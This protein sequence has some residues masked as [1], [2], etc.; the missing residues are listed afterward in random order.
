VQDRS[1]REPRRARARGGAT[2]AAG[3]R[4]RNGGDDVVHAGAWT[5]LEPLE[6]RVLLSAD[7]WSL[8]GLL[9]GVTTTASSASIGMPARAPRVFGGGGGGGGGAT[10]VTPGQALIRLDQFFADPRFAGLSG[11]GASS[12]II[13]SGINLSH[14]FFGP[15]ANGDGIA[16]RIRYQYDFADNDADAS[17]HDGHGTNVAGIV[18]GSDGVYPGVAPGAGIIA[19]K[20]F[21]DNGAGAF[22][23]VERALQWTIVNAAAYGIVSVNLSLG[24]GGNWASAMSRYGLGDE[25]AALAAINVIVVAA[26]GN[27]YFDAGSVQGI[28]YPASDPS[29]LAVGAVYAG[30]YGPFFYGGGAQADVTGADVIAPFSQRST[31]VSTLFAP[32]APITGPGLGSGLTT[33]H[34]TSQASP[35]V[36][37]AAVLAN[38]VAERYLGRR[39][40]PSEFR[41]LVFSTG[42]LVV[43]GDDE[44]DNAVNTGATFKRIDMLALGG[45]IYDLANPGGGGGGGGGNAAPTLGNIVTLGGGRPNR[46][47]RLTYS[48]LAAA[49]DEADADGTV[50]RFKIVQVT[51]GMV[52]KGGVPVTPGV[53]TLG[54]GEN[55][56]WVPGVGATGVTTA[57][58]VVATDGASDSATPV[59]VKI[60]LASR[61][62]L[63]QASQAGLGLGEVE[64]GMP[65]GRESARSG[66]VGAGFLGA[67]VS[68]RA[69]VDGGSG[70]ESGVGERVPLSS[71]L[72]LA[73]G[74]VGGLLARV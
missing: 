54:P 71:E 59:G 36:A 17:D 65:P 34:G 62:G 35:H 55:L 19:L 24:D 30:T 73:D 8:S 70:P 7:P 33:M 39:L 45:A 43:D 41:S 56:I 66:G 38:Q 6:A 27:G 64:E 37:G 48:V 5:G 3:W 4:T 23:A 18:A 51:S 57:F 44:Q 49:A 26:A 14:P 46:P 16:D 25:L 53:T 13:D 22:S 10:A 15:D 72:F 69:R 52:F 31:V 67:G 12:V 21:S 20:V 40:T 32:G 11:A 50:V 74:S 61:L 9:A 28:A 60:L 2:I 29:V 63:R 42:A 47:G 1:A 68:A 58:T